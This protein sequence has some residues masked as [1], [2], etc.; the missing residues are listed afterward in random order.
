MVAVGR[1]KWMPRM[2]VV[3]EKKDAAK[4]ENENGKDRKQTDTER[5][6]SDILGRI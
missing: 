6:Y 1:I 5:S 2:V 3:T 4:K